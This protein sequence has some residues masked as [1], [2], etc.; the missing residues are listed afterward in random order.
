M[1]DVPLMDVADCRV[2]GGFAAVRGAEVVVGVWDEEG[3]DVCE[4]FFVDVAGWKG[5]AEPAFWIVIV[6]VVVQVFGFAI[7]VIFI[8]A[9]PEDDGGMVPKE[10]HISCC[11]SLHEIEKLVVRRIVTTREEEVLPD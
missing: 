1:P 3:G 8:V 7:L 9:C 4:D 2:G 5:A 10:F 6:R 11:F